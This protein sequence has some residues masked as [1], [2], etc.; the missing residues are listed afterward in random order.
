MNIEGAHNKYSASSI[1]V[2]TFFKY[3][4]TMKIKKLL[5]I[6]QDIYVRRGYFGGRCEVFGNAR[7]GEFIHH[8]DYSGMYG[9]CMLEDFPIGEGKLTYEGKWKDIGIHTI[10]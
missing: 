8:F 1:S 4:N 6:E 10:R 3:F 5:P 9:Q 7:D 2:Y